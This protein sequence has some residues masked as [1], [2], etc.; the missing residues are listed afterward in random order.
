LNNIWKNG[1]KSS[2]ER[3]NERVCYQYCQQPLNYSNTHPADVNDMVT[4]LYEKP[5]MQ[6]FENIII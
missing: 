6:F 4:N 1:D 2:Y 3:K 5:S